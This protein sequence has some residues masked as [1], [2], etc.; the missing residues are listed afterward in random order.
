VARTAQAKRTLSKS[1]RSPRTSRR[2]RSTAARPASPCGCKECT[3]ADCASGS[4]QLPDRLHAL[5]GNLSLAAFAAAILAPQATG[6]TPMAV[7]ALLL[8]QR[9]WR[10]AASVAASR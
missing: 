3:D 5:S 2:R 10:G 1:T 6:S 4:D 8:A 9:F 7:V